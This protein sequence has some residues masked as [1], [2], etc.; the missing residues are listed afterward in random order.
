MS[1]I[2]SVKKSRQWDMTHEHIRM[3]VKNYYVILVE[4]GNTYLNHFTVEKGTANALEEELVKFIL[5]S[6]F[7]LLYTSPSP[8]D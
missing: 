8:R 6:Y 7:C 1:I 3:V 4:P 2:Y 5:K